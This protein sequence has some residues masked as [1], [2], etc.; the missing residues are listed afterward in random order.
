MPRARS[1]ASVAA[2]LVLL[3]AGCGEDAAQ[4]AAR[5][6]VEARVRG[7]DTHC[8]RTARE[9]LRVVPTKLYLCLVERGDGACDEYAAIRHGRRF[10]VRLRRRDVDCVLPVG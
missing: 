7:G 6:A 2:V 4:H 1:A 3:A 10:E 9:Y 5:R 8:T